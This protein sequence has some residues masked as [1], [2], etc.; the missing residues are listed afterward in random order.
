MP[1][2]LPAADARVS[3]L[4]AWA[5]SAGV[6]SPVS[7]S[8]P[9]R[10][11]AGAWPL[12]A[13]PRSRLIPLAGSALTVSPSRRMTASASWAAALPASAAA[14]HNGKALARFLG[15]TRPCHIRPASAWHA[16]VGLVSAFGSAWARGGRSM[17]A[18]SHAMHAH[19]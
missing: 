1:W 8:W 9:R 13:A 6:R 19:R 10:A 7:S 15:T 17:R 5:T 12:A 16:C 11:S 18:S 3:R 4:T 14:C 2:A